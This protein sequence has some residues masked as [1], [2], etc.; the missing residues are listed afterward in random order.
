MEWIYCD[1]DGTLTEDSEGAFGVLREDV[2]EKLRTYLE[3]TP[4]TRLVL[5]SGR[6]GEYAQQFAEAH[7]ID[8]DYCIAK[9]HLVIDDN[10][11]IRPYRLVSP[12]EFLGNAT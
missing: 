5:W 2:L 6:G 12:E 7:G 11:R 10:P 9:P 1:I 8:A 3:R 4:D